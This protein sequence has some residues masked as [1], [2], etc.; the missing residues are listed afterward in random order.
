MEQPGKDTCTGT[1]QTVKSKS[2][3][4]NKCI[5]PH[6]PPSRM[7]AQ[8]DWELEMLPDDVFKILAPTLPFTIPTRTPS[9]SPF[10]PANSSAAQGDP[11]NPSPARK[12][13]LKRQSSLQGLNA[14]AGA[15]KD[16]ERGPGE[17]GD[18]GDGTPAIVHEFS[19]L[20]PRVQKRAAGLLRMHVLGSV[21][22]RIEV[23]SGA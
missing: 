16:G 18:E 9:P 19:H 3:H 8:H 7:R 23:R 21:R 12:R 2:S 11:P 5:H 14:A 20:S 6:S 4:T 22:S 17:D 15:A 1:K 10:K 13:Q